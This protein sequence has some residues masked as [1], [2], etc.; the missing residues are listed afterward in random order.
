MAHFRHKYKGLTIHITEINED[1]V[2][3]KVT[4]EDGSLIDDTEGFCVTVAEAMKTC[5]EMITDYY[6]QDKDS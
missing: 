2:D 1:R 4:E 5:K 6:D 3:Y